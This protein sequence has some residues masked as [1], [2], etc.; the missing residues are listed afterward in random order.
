MIPQIYAPSPALATHVQCYWTLESAPEHTPTR[1][2]I[3]PDGTMKLIF[4][5]GDPYC[6]H[7]PS[8][9][10]TLLPRCFLIG[11]LTAPYVV[12]P[13]GATGTFVVRF[14]PNGFFPFSTIPLKAM[15][16]T[17]V[18]LEVL[19]GI[20]GVALG[21]Q[22]LAA[23]TP[24]ARIASLEAFLLRRLAAGTGTDGRIQATLQTI[25]GAQGHLTVGQLSRQLH[26]DPR[27]LARSYA[28]EVG[29]SPKQLSKTIRLQ[30]TLKSLLTQEV[31]KLTELA[32]AH[33][34]FDQAHFIKDFRA[35]TGLTP[36]QFYGEALRMSLIFDRKA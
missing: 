7:S 23:S 35:F 10:R 28:R 3:V 14:H 16:N 2:T 12:E 26:I 31:D 21:A 15:V 5:Y 6:H 20:D 33:Q 25:V 19:F 32:Y 34:Y 11:Q 1:N 36:K 8:L 13:L 29:L 27:Q 9:G 30:A 24:A 4:H 18:P 17:A 22:I